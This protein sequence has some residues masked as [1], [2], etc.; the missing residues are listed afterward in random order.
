MNLSKKIIIGSANFNE[1]YG[2]FKKKIDILELELIVNYLIK[3]NQFFFETSIGYKNSI[4]LLN[5]LIMKKDYKNYEYILKLSNDDKKINN[6]INNKYFLKKKLPK[7]IMAHN[8]KDFLDIK[9]RNDL[10]EFSNK[11]NIKIGVS[12]YNKSEIS[13]VLNCYKPDVIQIPINLIDQRLFKDGTLKLL[14]NDGIEIHARSIF[15]QGLFFLSEKQ[16]I[17]KFPI[18]KD[19]LKIFTKISK[20]SKYSLSELSFL[21]VNSIQEVDK[22]I[23]GID[24]LEQLKKNYELLNYKLSSNLF[25]EIININFNDNSVLNPSLWPKK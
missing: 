1:E 7:I 5:N 24:N 9:F 20:I 22:I 2:I 25:S 6:Q 13:D 12:V 21:W 3:N 4:N 14:K 17:S 19:I 11:N 23:I 16:I 10:I 8:A 18:L 15:L